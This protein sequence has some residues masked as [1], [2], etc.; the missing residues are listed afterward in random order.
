MNK[1]Q[2]T[3]INAVA[4]SGL[5]LAGS[6]YA[7]C[8]ADVSTLTPGTWCEAPNSHLSSVAPAGWS[9]N[10]MNPWSS[11]AYD[12]KRDRL[13]VWGG[14][15]S[16]YSGNE[17]YVFD[18]NTLKWQRLNNPSDPPGVDTAYAPDGGPTSRHTYNYIEYVPSI[19]RFCS[20]G[21][22][23]FYSSGQT[24]TNNTDCFNFDT[25][26]WERKASVPSNGGYIIGAKAVFDPVSQKVYHQTGLGGA[27]SSYDPATNTWQV[28]NAYSYMDYYLTA[29]IDPVRRKMIAVGVNQQVMWDLKNPTAG[30]TTLSTSGDTTITSAQSPGVVY[31]PVSD[32]FVAW[33]GGANVYTL[34]MDTRVWTRV[35]PASTNTVIPTAANNTGTYGRF[36]YIPS[37]NAF[38]VVNSIDEN[39]FIYKLSTGQV[40]APP[41]APAKPTLTI[42]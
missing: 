25:L 2:L 15:H 42:K 39:V 1:I 18:V 35:A 36:R 7:A 16:D 27:F 30:Y 37:K 38:I 19:D 20:F 12:T 4:L 5:F 41:Q 29:A 14:G 40:V 33:S 17:I 24:G 8:P 3:Y 26:R 31:D 9:A 10:V 6:A 32:K 34:N 11:A 13:I 23:G 28:Q 21:G 22:A